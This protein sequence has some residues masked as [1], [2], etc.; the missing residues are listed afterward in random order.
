MDE[1]FVGVDIA[2]EK[3]IIKLLKQLR[4]N[5]KTIVV[6]HH[7]LQTLHDYFDWVLLL[8]I[9]TIACGPVHDV[10]V[11]QYICATYGERDLL[12]QK[13]QV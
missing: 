5:G 13:Q 4:S 11:P 6:V 9:E 7:D 3:T 2:T 12:G 10:L 1:P 8:N